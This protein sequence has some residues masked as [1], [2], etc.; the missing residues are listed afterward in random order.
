MKD[1][2]EGKKVYDE[3]RRNY[4]KE[5]F[6]K[7]GDEEHNWQ[8]DAEMLEDEILHIDDISIGMSAIYD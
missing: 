3:L 7:G 2:A 8:Q 6:H 4:K 1:D 5:Y